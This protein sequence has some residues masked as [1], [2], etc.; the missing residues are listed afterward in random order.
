MS[1]AAATLLHMPTQVKR[2]TDEAINLLGKSDEYD[3]W[4]KRVEADVSNIAA[5]S[6]AIGIGT[7]ACKQA[8]EQ[9]LASM[10]QYFS[11]SY[12]KRHTMHTCLLQGFLQRPD[13]L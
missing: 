11:F 4:L 6:K 7:F 3:A 1:A 12:S 2:H 9:L 5:V 10:I 13:R 8:D